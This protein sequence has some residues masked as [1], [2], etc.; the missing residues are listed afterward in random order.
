MEFSGHPGKGGMIQSQIRAVE[1]PPRE[2]ISMFQEGKNLER[3][4]IISKLAR[5]ILE[6]ILVSGWYGEAKIVVSV[7]DGRIKSV[8]KAVQREY[9]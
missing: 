9:R 7:M 6:E 8:A 5:E 3:R 4:E 2:A 1:A